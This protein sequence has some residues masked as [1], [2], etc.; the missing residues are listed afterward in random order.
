[1]LDYEQGKI[2]FSPHR[3]RRGEDLKD[4]ALN[5]IGKS[6]DEKIDLLKSINA[7]QLMLLG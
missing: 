6:Q 2:F 5:R 7:K 3:Q 1:M 4:L